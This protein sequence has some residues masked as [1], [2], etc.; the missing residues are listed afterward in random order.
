MSQP[1][2]PSVNFCDWD[3]ALINDR[4]KAV[5]TRLIAKYGEPSCGR[6]RAAFISKHFVIKF[7]RSDSGIHDNCVESS[8]SDETTAKSRGFILDGFLCVIQ[9]R[10]V[11]P[12][13]EQRKELPAWTDFIDCR[14]VG[15]D[16]K[17]N[18]K[19]YDFA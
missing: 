19:A 8:Y 15:Y 11:M 7:P 18:V 1:T 10:L 2:I 3:D 17:G 14:Q 12:T 13:K 4:A 16:K 5:L 9:E 6:N